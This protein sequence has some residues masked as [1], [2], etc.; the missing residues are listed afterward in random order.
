MT[1]TYWFCA[2]VTVLSA[3]TSL[4]FSIAALASGGDQLNARYAFSRSLALAMA[5]AI[6]LFRSSETWVEAMASAMVAVQVAD[7]VV[8]GL[9]RDAMKAV[10][11]AVLATINVVAL[12]LLIR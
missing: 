10:G 11:P 9:Q 4:G 6:A 5:S 1:S 2:V 8:G 3:F 12:V 7:A